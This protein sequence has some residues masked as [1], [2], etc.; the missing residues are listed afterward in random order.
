MQS[1]QPLDKNVKFWLAASLFSLFVYTAYWTI[2]SYE[3]LFGFIFNAPQHYIYV[4]T[5]GEVFWAGHIGLTARTAAVL[6]GLTTLYLLWIKQKPLSK[7]KQ[8][9][10]LALFLESVNFIGLLPSALWL[11]KPGTLVYSPPLGIGYLLQVLL[12]AP[13]LTTLAIKLKNHSPNEHPTRFWVFA[14]AAFAGYISAL[15]INGLSRWAGMISLDNVAFLFEGTRLSGF[16][17]TI[18]LLPSA[19]AFAV[20]GLHHAAKQHMTSMLK[21]F[22]A[23]LVATG[24][25]YAIYIAYSYATNTLNMAPLVDIWTAPL[26]GLGAALINTTRQTKNNENWS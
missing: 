21:W 10:T 14:A 8:A 13:L 15:A 12:T 4:T 17:N 20:L 24:L 2:K 9:V 25:H 22:G 16:L 18:I 19:A 3:H 5:L 26:L 11:L 1:T 6:I 23:S 7:I